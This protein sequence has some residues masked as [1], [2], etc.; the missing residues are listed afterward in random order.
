[1]ASLIN[2]AIDGTSG[3]G[4]STV[5]KK[6]ANALSLT[7]LDTGAM[8]RSIAYFLQENDDNLVEK[9]NDF[10]I[11]MKENQIIL[12]G[13]DITN[14]I[15]NDRISLLASRYAKIPEV[16]SFLVKKQQEIAKNKGYILDGR[17][18][19]SVV[20]KDAEVKLFLKADPL[21]RAKRRYNEYVAKQQP[22]DLDEIYKAMC[23]R[24]YQDM[25]RS[26]SPLVI[27]E[28]AFVIDT[29]DKSIDNVVKIAL[30]YVESKVKK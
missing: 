8:Y 30:D 20:L 4:K 7:H 29:S 25:N 9:L 24:D 6:I 2:I 16:R 11:E 14:E 1:M 28:D 19:G 22:A 3:V 5:A 15:R 18:I 26:V 21:V 27:V 17:D 10:H 12:N 23:E 13:K